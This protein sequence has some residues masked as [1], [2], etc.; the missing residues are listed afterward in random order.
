MKYI[1]LLAFVPFVG[2]LGF[3]PFV[4]RVTPYILGMP[5]ILFWM[6]LWVVITSAAMGAIYKFDPACRED[7]IE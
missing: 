3:L 5:F 7:D 6:V 4:N 2:M 1:R